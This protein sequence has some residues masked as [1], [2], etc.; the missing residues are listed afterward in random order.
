M[1]DTAIW[2]IIMGL[3][4]LMIGISSNVS[5]LRNDITRMNITLDKIAEQIGV[6]NTVKETTDIELKNLISEGKRIKAIK[7]Y[8][9]VTGVGLKEA[10]EYVDSLMEQEL[11]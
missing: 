1:N 6:P 7:R 2:A 3:V 8:R 11:K 5:Q 10:K 4:A 9:M